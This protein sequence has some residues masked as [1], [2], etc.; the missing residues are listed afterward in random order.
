MS[1]YHLVFKGTPYGSPGPGVASGVISSV[2]V[3][4]AGKAL[5]NFILDVGDTTSNDA[6]DGDVVV[7]THGT[8]FIYGIFNGWSPA[9]PGQGSFIVT[10]D[11]EMYSL[12]IQT[13]NGFSVFISGYGLYQ[14]LEEV[15]SYRIQYAIEKAHYSNRMTVYNTKL[16]YSLTIDD[17][18]RFLVNNMLPALLST[19]LYLVDSCK[20]QGSVAYKIVMNSSS[21]DTLNNKFKKAIEFKIAVP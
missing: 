6:I 20:A 2:T 13:M 14:S 10:Y 8:D 9:E 4:G 18:R 11:N 19:E 12:N 21:F 7:L 17:K 16:E 3:I 1:N 15:N 5:V